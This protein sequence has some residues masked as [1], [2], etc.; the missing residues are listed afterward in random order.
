LAPLPRRYVVRQKLWLGGAIDYWINALAGRPPN[1][2][3]SHDKSLDSNKNGMVR[4][5]GW[6]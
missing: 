1:L 6:H 2:P 5:T 3:D 4:F